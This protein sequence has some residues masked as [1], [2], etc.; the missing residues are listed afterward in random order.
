VRLRGSEA[1]KNRYQNELNILQR[2]TQSTK[3]QF[4]TLQSEIQV[5]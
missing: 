4:E 5:Q 2:S 1:D 3:E